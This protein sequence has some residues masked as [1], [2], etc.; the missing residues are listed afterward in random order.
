VSKSLIQKNKECSF[1]R[2]H[3]NEPT[4]QA[5]INFIIDQYKR[6]AKQ[7]NLDYILSENEF[8]NLIKG[9]CYYCN[10]EPQPKKYRNSRNKIKTISY[11][12]IDRV[13]SSLGYNKNNCISC[14]EMCNRMKMAYKQQDF[15]EQIKKIHANLLN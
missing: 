1:C 3:G 10:T 11:N 9:N 8:I 13:D 14:C 2:K 15:L 6:G 12:G 4:E 5:Q 7:R